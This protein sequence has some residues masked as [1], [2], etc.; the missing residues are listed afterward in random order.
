VQQAVASV[1]VLPPTATIAVG[2]TQ[3]FSAHPRDAGGTDIAGPFSPVWISSNTTVATLA[4]NV[5][6]TATATGKSSGG[7]ITITATVSNISGTA[8]LTV[9]APSVTVNWGF[10]ADGTTTTIA[11]GTSITWHNVD[12]GIPHSI[13]PDTVPPPSAAGPVTGVNDISTQTF[14]TPGTYHYHCGVHPT[15]MHGTIVVQ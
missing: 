15:T 5:D 13:A 3:I 11:A 14:N 6:G 12:S 4:T 8:L 7:P 2:A 1:A 9:T 10:A